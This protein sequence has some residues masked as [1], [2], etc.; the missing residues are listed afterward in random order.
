[1]VPVIALAQETT[2]TIRVTVLGPDGNASAGDQVS[3][4]D[5]RTGRTTSSATNDS[6]VISQRGLN[7][8]GPYTVVVSSDR[9]ANQTVTD[10]NLHLGDTYDVVLQLGADV[11][12]EVIVT[13]AALNGTMVA[14]GPNS[15]FGLSQL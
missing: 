11:L 14:M 10:I 13:A 2:S 5:T 15:I 9:Y 6:G 3:I 12:E 1:M 7:V 4:T 8:G